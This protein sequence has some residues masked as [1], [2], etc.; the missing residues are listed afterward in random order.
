MARRPIVVDLGLR[1]VSEANGR[2]HWRKVAAR[3]RAH[4]AMARLVLQMHAR[5]MGEADQFTITLTRV[6]PRKLDDDNLASGF[7]AVRDGVA[8]WLGIDDGSPRIKWQY[9]QHKGDAGH[10]TAWV[11][12]EWVTPC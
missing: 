1:I 2:E 12:V 8:D 10:Y 3:K 5:P 4:R 11:R 7:K 9:A 6:A